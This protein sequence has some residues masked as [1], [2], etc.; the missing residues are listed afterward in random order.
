MKNNFPAREH[1]LELQSFLV[2]LIL[3]DPYVNVEKCALDHCPQPPHK[4]NGTTVP[5]QGNLPLATNLPLWSFHCYLNIKM[6]CAR[7]LAP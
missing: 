3:N 1:F 6:I 2:V 7:T 4:P 5:S